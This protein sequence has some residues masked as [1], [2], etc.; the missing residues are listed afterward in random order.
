VAG[1]LYAL[2]DAAVAH[3]QLGN[4]SKAFDLCK[5][6]VPGGVTVTTDGRVG[7]LRVMVRPKERK[8]WVDYAIKADQKTPDMAT[9]LLVTGWDAAPIVERN[10][11]PL[12]GKLATLT[13]DGKKAFVVPLFADAAGAVPNDL[14]ARAQRAQKLFATLACESDAFLNAVSAGT[15]ADARNIIKMV[16]PFVCVQLEASALPASSFTPELPPMTRIL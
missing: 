3:F 9:A 6:L 13:V 2:H 4:M 10:G 5:Q 12:A 8:L 7:L 16:N 11:V 1:L 15:G 14:A